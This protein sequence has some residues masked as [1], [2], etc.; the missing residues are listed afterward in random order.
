MFL[1]AA[2]FMTSL[3]LSAVM[4]L[5]QPLKASTL[6]QL[7]FLSA[8]AFMTSLVLSAVMT[9]PQPLIASTLK[10]LVFLPFGQSSTPDLSVP[11]RLRP[12]AR[13]LAN[14]SN[15]YISTDPTGELLYECPF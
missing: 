8:A 11:V 5:H 1:S 3:V 7:V 13:E 10:Q 9:L 12:A 15:I 4:T 14:A 6:K 2:A